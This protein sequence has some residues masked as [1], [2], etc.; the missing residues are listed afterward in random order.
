M[1]QPSYRH[2]RVYSEPYEVA[3]RLAD[4][5]L[6]VDLVSEAVVR[7]D[8]ERANAPV[9]GYEGHPEYN[10]GSRVLS[11]ICEEGGRTDG[12]W[13]RENYLKI[14]VAVS[15]DNK[16]AIHATAGSN[17]T[18][19]RDGDPTNN[20]LKGPHSVKASSA[21]LAMVPD[22]PPPDFYFLLTR[23]DSEGLWAELFRPIMDPSG[24]AVGYVER[25]LF[26]SMDHEGSRL[27]D[28]PAVP[29]MGVVPVLRRA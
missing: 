15:G 20:S 14:P 5:H 17:G 13:R 22:E 21:Q 28:V 25:V 3:A 18:G 16:V 7:G 10:A 8:V 23:R 12:A 26:G 9:F 29:P 6:T 19:Q 24:Y 2:G 4:L 11:T 1:P 27:R